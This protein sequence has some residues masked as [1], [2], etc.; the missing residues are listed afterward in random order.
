MFKWIFPRPRELDG[1]GDK[2]FPRSGS[3][4]VPERNFSLPL[5]PFLVML[6]A[7]SLRFPDDLVVLEG[8]EAR[9]MTLQGLWDETWG[10]EL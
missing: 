7:P 5:Y 2:E 3:G 4:T 6:L 1:S 9:F 8:P 10:N